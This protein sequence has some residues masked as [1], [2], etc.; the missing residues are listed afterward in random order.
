MRKQSCIDFNQILNSKQAVLILIRIFVAT[1]YLTH[2][3]ENESVLLP[4]NMTELLN[5]SVLG[6]YAQRLRVLFLIAASN[7]I[8]PVIFVVIELI[9]V[10]RKLSNMALAAI[11][12]SG[13]NIEIIGILFATSKSYSIT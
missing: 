12:I 6:S 9:F 7:F 11:N 8:F 10:T 3:K 2:S 5:M 13:T 1:G 4:V